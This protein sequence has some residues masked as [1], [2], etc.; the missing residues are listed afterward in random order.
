[1]SLA[2]GGWTQWSGLLATFGVKQGWVRVVNETPSGSFVA[3]GV[4]NDGA[5]PGSPAGTDDGSFVPAVPGTAAPSTAWRFAVVGDTHVTATSSAVPAEIVASI[6]RD[7]VDLVL[8]PG[9]VVEGGRGATRAQMERQLRAFLDVTAP[10]RA[11]GIGV[12]P[13]RGN[14]EDDVP[15]GKAAWSAVF[16]GA[17]ALPGDGPAGETGLTYSFTSKNALFVG[18]DEYA[19][20]H[21]V[22]QSWLDARLSAN[23]LPHVFVFGHE[24]AFQ[25]NHADC[26]GAWPAERNAFWRSLAAA[27]ARV[28]FAGHDHFF[29]ALRAD[30]GNGDE[31]DDLLQLVVGTGGGTLFQ[32]AAYSGDNAPYAPVAL[33]HDAEFG[34]LLVEVSGSGSRD[35]SLTLAWKKRMVDA[36]T[37]AV[38][39][40]PSAV[41]RTS[42]AR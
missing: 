4:V 14:H 25:T 34:Y 18:L 9:D 22:N 21:R 11:A 5:T 10:L 29:D 15:D 24:A 6:L 32:R 3:Y 20:L 19:S 1:M 36:A 13:V 31:T 37:G 39:Y 28:T 35:A 42:A 17:D 23:D 12:Y 8:V 26:L 38:A 33:Q 7:G 27:G 2:P 40:V 30:D 41:I 16:S